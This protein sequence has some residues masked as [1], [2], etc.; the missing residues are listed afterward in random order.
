M[1]YASFL[2]DVVKVSPEIVKFYSAMPHPLFGVGIDAVSAQDA[3]GFSMPGFDAMKLDPAPGKGMNR[4]AIPNDEAQK[5]FFHFPDGNASIARMMVRKLVPGVLPGHTA[6]DIV[7]ARANYAKLDAGGPVRIRLNSTAV[8]VKHVGDA[9]SAKE[10]EVVYARGGKVYAARAA[11]CIL[12]CWH[13]VV[14]LHLRGIAGE[15]EGSAGFG[16]ES[17]AALHQRRAAKLEGF[18]EGQGQ[19]VLC[20]WDVPHLYEPGPAGEH[21]RLPVLEKT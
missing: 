10:V 5:Y 12:A 9:A 6:E 13:V 11:N 14:P 1:S 4:D 16:G 17:P 21:R 8:R 19:L 15:A 3:W 2:T 18:R 20:A 7:L